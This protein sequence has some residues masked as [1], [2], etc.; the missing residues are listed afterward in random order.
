[1]R[2]IKLKKFIVPVVLLALILNDIQLLAKSPKR[3]TSTKSK[4]PDIS[5]S[6]LSLLS[7][8]S[9]SFGPGAHVKMHVKKTMNLALLKKNKVSEGEL[10]LDSGKMRLELDGQE[11]TLVVVTGSN[12]WVVSYPPAEFKDAP[13]QVI[14]ANLKSKSKQKLGLAALLT[15]SGLTQIFKIVSARTAEQSVI[16]NLAP[17]KE[18]SDFKRVEIQIDPG[19]KLITKMSYW[20]DLDNQSDYEFTSVKQNMKFSGDKFKFSPSSQDEVTTVE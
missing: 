19:T 3:Q 14:K 7:E 5:T 11:K 10:L 9:E 8:A 1:M 16:Y 12:A 15:G 2:K 17:R 13:R 4:S 18:S 6:Q 20:D